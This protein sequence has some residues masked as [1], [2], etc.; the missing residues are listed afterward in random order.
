MIG[1]KAYD[2]DGLDEHILQ[3]YETKSLH[4]IEERN[5]RHKMVED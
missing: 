5:N 1:D 3:Q 4:R 2:S